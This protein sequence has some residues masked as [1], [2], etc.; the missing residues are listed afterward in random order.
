PAVRGYLALV[1]DADCRSDEQETVAS[2]VHSGLDVDAA[3]DSVPGTDPQRGDE[4]VSPARWGVLSAV[5]LRL[6]IGRQFSTSAW[7]LV[8][9]IDHVTH[10][11][12]DRHAGL[13]VI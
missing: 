5:D 11:C 2:S 8:H 7:V 9:A 3:E 1:V 10:D 6:E 12:A 13:P 4:V